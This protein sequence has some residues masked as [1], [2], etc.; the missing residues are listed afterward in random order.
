MSLA[1][2]PTN[3]MLPWDEETYAPVIRLRIATRSAHVEKLGDHQLADSHYHNTFPKLYLLHS[4]LLHV[5]TGALPAKFYRCL[6]RSV[7]C[8][9]LVFAVFPGS[10][11]CTWQRLRVAWP[12]YFR[13]SQ[14][15]TEDLG[16]LSQF[17]VL[18]L[19]TKY[20]NTSRTRT[21]I[22]RDAHSCLCSVVFFLSC[23]PCEKF[24]IMPLIGS[25]IF[26]FG[27]P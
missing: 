13:D 4:E 23:R 26:G 16:F 25:G 12:T 17:S 21:G 24:W 19:R 9:V 14:S 8:T 18:N 22:A 5:L 2:R 6:L 20:I 7:V 1:P 10:Y 15:R 3:N 11:F 27:H